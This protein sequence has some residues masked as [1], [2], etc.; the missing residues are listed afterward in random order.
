MFRSGDGETLQKAQGFSFSLRHSIRQKHELIIY[1]AQN[2]YAVST[3]LYGRVFSRHMRFP[4][5]IV[6]GPEITGS[7]APLGN[8]PLQLIHQLL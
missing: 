4:A 6:V 3:D 8:D 2:A 7:L 5:L 1:Y